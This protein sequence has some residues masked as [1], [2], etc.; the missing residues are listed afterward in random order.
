MIVSILATG[1][2]ILVEAMPG[3][4][5]ARGRDL[6]AKSVSFLREILFAEDALRRGAMLD[7]DRD[8]IGSGGLLGELSGTAPVRGR[9]PLAVAPLL[10]RHAPKTPTRTGPALSQ[11]GY[12]YIVC[13]PTGPST[14]S[15]EPSASFDDELAERRFLAYAWPESDKGIV[16]SVFVLD[17][18][19][20]IL[21]DKNETFR[22][23]GPSR[24]P[25]C[26]D[27]LSPPSMG[28]YKPWR[29]KKPRA[30]LP[31]DK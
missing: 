15:A 20:R 31:G 14:F 17:E 9:A 7:P 2:F 8:G 18:H 23:F 16:K 22:V 3:I 26:E 4:I 19:E 11:D 1:R 10:P 24:S 27:V 30:S 28:L 21:E 5:E 25:S 6:S 13:L 29:G 12:L